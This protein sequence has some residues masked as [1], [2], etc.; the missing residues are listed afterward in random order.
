MRLG[1]RAAAAFGGTA[2]IAGYGRRRTASAGPTCT[3]RGLTRWS[4]RR[5]RRPSDRLADLATGGRVQGLAIG[6]GRI[7]LGLAEPGLEASTHDRPPVGD[8]PQHVV[9]SEAEKGA[10]VAPTSVLPPIGVPPHEHHM[11]ASAV[12][13]PPTYGIRDPTPSR[14]ADPTTGLPR[15]P[16][17]LGRRSCPMVG[18]HEASVAKRA[19]CTAS[20]H[21]CHDTGRQDDVANPCHPECA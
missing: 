5:P 12:Q 21:V 4:A 2:T 3:R 6:T 7:A 8:Q 19:Q 13:K 11:S 15:T 16:V 20:I 18:S 17:P 1:A 14:L 9:I 10:A